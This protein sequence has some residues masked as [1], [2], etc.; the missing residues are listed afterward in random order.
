MSSQDLKL[1][2]PENQD[3]GH[4]IEKPE[5]NG[6]FP[7]ERPAL[8]RTETGMF[9]PGNPGGPGRPRNEVSIT[10]AYKDVLAERGP[11]PLAE[12]VYNDA[13]TAKAP[14]DRLAA[15]SEIADRV[16]GKATQNIRHA[17]VFL[18]AA[19]GAETMAA[20]DEWAEDE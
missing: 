19:P 12:M 6:N 7:A 14:R 17:G 8:T 16:D 2:Q 4:F 1:A 15:A 5:Q 18:V 9:A 10:A 20:L 13:L 3:F 11:K